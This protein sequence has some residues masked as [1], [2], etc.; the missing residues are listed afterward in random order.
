MKDLSAS[1]QSQRLLAYLSDPQSCNHGINRF[2]AEQQLTICHL[3]R[4][5]LDLKQSGYVFRH[6]NEVSKDL[7]GQAHRNIR[8]YWLVGRMS[9]IQSV[10]NLAD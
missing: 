6:C 10:E 9:P 2:E 8:R 1:A 5:V 3:A 4:R 7:A